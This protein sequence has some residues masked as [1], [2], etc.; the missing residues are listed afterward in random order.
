MA[1]CQGGEQVCEQVL[2]KVKPTLEDFILDSPISESN[3]PP[4]SREEN[5]AN[6]KNGSKRLIE[7]PPYYCGDF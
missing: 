2:P 1:L 3:S 5:K 4:R 6:V 7:D